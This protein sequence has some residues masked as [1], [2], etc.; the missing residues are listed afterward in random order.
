MQA[1][2]F[3]QAKCSIILPMALFNKLS[4]LELFQGILCFGK[5]VERATLF[6]LMN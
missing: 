2:T 4:M 1:I 3:M 6:A 5:I